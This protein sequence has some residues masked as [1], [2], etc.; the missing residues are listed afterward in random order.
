MERTRIVTL[1]VGLI[2]LC[3]MLAGARLMAQA[4]GA[5]KGPVSMTASLAVS[6][7]VALGEPLLVKYNVT[8]SSE[9]PAS[10][11]TKEANGEPLIT[12]TFTEVGGKALVPTVS[13][14]FLYKGVNALHLWNGL[15]IPGDTSQ[16]WQELANAKISFPHAGSYVLRVH[17]QMPYVVGDIVRGEHYILSSNYVFPLKVI[18]VKP[19][20]LHVTAERLRVSILNTTDV[21]MKTILIEALLSMPEVSA[22]T[23]WQSLIENP[24]LDGAT[25]DEIAS[26][27]A[28]HQTL[29]SADLLAEMFW[30][31]TQS[32]NDVAEASVFQHFYAMYDAGTPALRKHIEDLHKQRGVAM[33]NIRLE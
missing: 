2:G 22:A 16:S 30:E 27:L 13:R 9:Q 3:L 15:S 1:S 20:E 6:S 32:P 12:E 24:K 10:V 7:T 5:N 17:V 33:S 19:S 26:A 14:V 31:A 21:K 18:L 25:L 29:K 11:F 23:S 8:N 28:D 4:E